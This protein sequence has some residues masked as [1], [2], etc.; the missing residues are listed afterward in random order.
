MGS[1]F[2]KEAADANNEAGFKLLREDPLF[3]KDLQKKTS[4]RFPDQRIKAP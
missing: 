2:S 1:F 3:F 4:L